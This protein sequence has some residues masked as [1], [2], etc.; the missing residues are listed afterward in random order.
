MKSRT[1]TCITAMT[2][3]A[4][5]AMPVRLAAQEHARN[6]F[7]DM[8]RFGDSQANLRFDSR[9][10]NQDTARAG[11]PA[12]AQFTY[13]SIDFP[14][15]FGTRCFGLSDHRMIVGGYRLSPDSLRHAFILTNS[16]FAP[17]D[18]G[19]VLGADFSDALAINDRG[20]IVGEYIDDLGNDH[21]FLRSEGVLTTID[22][23][24]AI[25]TDASDIN[26]SGSIVGDFMDSAGVFHGFLLTHGVFTQIDV[27]GAL[28][29]EAIGIN[30][31]D[32]I[33][34]GWDTDPNTL[35]HAFVLL[36]GE[37]TTFDVPTAAPASTQA[38]GVNESG[39]VVGAYLDA[40]GN[41]HGFLALG[42]TFTTIDFPGA[43]D[44]SVWRINAARQI[45]G[46]YFDTSPHG[47]FAQPI[48]KEKP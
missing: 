17:L 39:H 37:F 32:E 18:P 14:G 34:G 44:T 21:G 41:E 29:T 13:N 5:L 30:S 12:H 6:K 3:F 2:L 27:P 8:G 4:A 42:A 46:N 43:M 11:S 10:N 25:I 22:F 38:L 28:D 16:V 35:G 45:V 48:P 24:G 47:Y 15:A 20:Q 1:L 31:G 19:G 36:H 9:L 26:N 23:P 40:A 33:V 7:I